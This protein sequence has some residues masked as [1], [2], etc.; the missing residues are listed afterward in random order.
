MCKHKLK[1]PTKLGYKIVLL[2]KVILSFAWAIPWVLLSL[3]LFATI[4][5]IIP[6]FLAL[7][8]GCYPFKRTMVTTLKVRHAWAWRD[9]LLDSDVEEPWEL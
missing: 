9:Q 6:G 4:V 8:I 2:I 7:A 1:D 3:L 5:F